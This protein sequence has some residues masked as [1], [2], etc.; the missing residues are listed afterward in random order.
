V[1]PPSGKKFVCQMSLK[2]CLRNVLSYAGGER[3]IRIVKLSHYGNA[4]DKGEA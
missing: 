2:C 3:N 4:D 1:L